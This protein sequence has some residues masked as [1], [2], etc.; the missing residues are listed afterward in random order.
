M[1]H[2]INFCR[3]FRTE[4]LKLTLQEIENLTFIK[5]KTLSAFEN[6]RSTNINHLNVYYGLCENRQQRNQFIKGFD[7]AMD[8]DN[9]TKVKQNDK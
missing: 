6:G 2:L 4:V 8:L 9:L 3:D 1:K 5:V 7:K